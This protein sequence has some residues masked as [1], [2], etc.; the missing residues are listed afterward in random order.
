MGGDTDVLV[1]AFQVVRVSDPERNF[2]VFYQILAGA[3]KEEK[4][5]WRLDGKTFEDFLLFEPIEMRKIGTHFRR[6]RVRRNSKRHEGGWYFEPEREDVF[7][8]VSGVLHLG[9]YQFRAKPGRRGRVRHP[10][11]VKRSLEDAAAVLKVDKD[12]LEKA[13][14]SRQIVTADGA[15]LKPLS[16]SD[17]KYNRDSLA[18]MLYSRLLIGSSKGINQAIGHKNDDDEYEESIESTTS[19]TKRRR[20][21]IGVLDI[22]GFESFKKNSFEQFCIN[23]ANEKLQQHFNQKC[24]KWNK[25]STKKKPSIGR[26]SNLWII[27]TF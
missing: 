1:G 9:E 4:S 8:V 15:I 5:N 14:I 27:R 19:D 16:V 6:G 21:F 7:R 11:D 22:Y 13:L 2:H 10:P 25:R 23:F 3:S 20:R 18:K 17:A 12:R 24:S 26:T